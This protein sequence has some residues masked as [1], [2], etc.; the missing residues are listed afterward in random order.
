MKVKS[1]KW[2]HLK[3][4][5]ERKEKQETVGKDKKKERIST[6]VKKKRY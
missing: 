3:E 2:D 1:K 5:E 6:K 4:A